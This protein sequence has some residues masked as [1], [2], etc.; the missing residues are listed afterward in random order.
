[1]GFNSLEDI[2]VWQKTREYF[3]FIFNISK[4]PPFSK[5]YRFKDQIRASSGSVTDNIAEGFGRGGNKEFINFLSI[6]KGSLEE[7]RSQLY[8][9]ND[10]HYITQEEFNQA[11]DMANTIAR[12]IASLQNYLKKS[13]M[14]GKKYNIAEENLLSY[15]S[16]EPRTQNTEKKMLD[17]Q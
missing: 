17:S 12:I 5:D 7:S 4:N 9:A 10:I 1:M 6:A 2:Q 13:E 11:I 15:E 14:K 8:R 3:K 16:P